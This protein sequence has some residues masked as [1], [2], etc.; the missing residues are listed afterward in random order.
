MLKMAIRR[1]LPRGIVF[2]L[3]I[4]NDSFGIQ[5]ENAVHL[6]KIFRADILSVVI[7]CSLIIRNC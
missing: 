7:C 3:Q 2:E 5:S 4:F 6:G 1:Y